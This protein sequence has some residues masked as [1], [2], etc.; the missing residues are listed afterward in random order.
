MRRRI[1][2]RGKTYSIDESRRDTW[3]DPVRELVDKL[4]AGEGE[5]G[6]KY[7]YRLVGSAVADVHRVLV[8]TRVSVAGNG[9]L[10]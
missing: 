3:A 1:Y 8:S 2:Q 9:K 6:E 7:A 5:S 4:R 10:I